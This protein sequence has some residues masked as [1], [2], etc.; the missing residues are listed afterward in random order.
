MPMELSAKEEV[1]FESIS[2]LRGGAERMTCVT[3]TFGFH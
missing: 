2:S 3:R 1:D